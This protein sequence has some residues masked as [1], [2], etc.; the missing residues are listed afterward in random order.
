MD[1]GVPRELQGSTFSLGSSV[2]AS[3]A[4]TAV[5]FAQMSEWALKKHKGY[6]K[7]EPQLKSRK[8]IIPFLL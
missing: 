3:W 2:L 8:A 7:A 4:F 6:V 5:G 1:L